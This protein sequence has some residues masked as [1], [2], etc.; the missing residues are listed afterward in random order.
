M[1]FY[2]P[3]LPYG[4]HYIFPSLRDC[5]TCDQVIGRPIHDE[6]SVIISHGVCSEDREISAPSSNPMCDA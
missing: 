2:S 6:G 3:A 4:Y 1:H 5:I